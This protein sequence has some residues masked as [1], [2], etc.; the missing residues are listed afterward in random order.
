[1]ANDDY[2]RVHTTWK[3]FTVRNTGN[4]SNDEFEK[5]SGAI[6]E[7]AK[8]NLISPY[9][10]LKTDSGFEITIGTFCRT[11]AEGM[12]RDLFLHLAKQV[13]RKMEKSVAYGKKVELSSHENS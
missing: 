2:A 5:I 7:R 1:M 12:T 3:F 6:A 8:E 13:F 4:F 10:L 11:G 9:Q